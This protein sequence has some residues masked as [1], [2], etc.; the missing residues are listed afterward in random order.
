[1]VQLYLEKFQRISSRFFIGI[2]SRAPPEIYCISFSAFSRNSSK[3]SWRCLYFL[4]NF[5]L[6]SF[7]NSCRNFL[8]DFS[9][10]YSEI[11]PKY[12][13]KLSTKFPFDNLNEI[14]YRDLS[15]FISDIFPGIPLEYCTG[16]LVKD[17]SRSSYKKKSQHTLSESHNNKGCSKHFPLEEKNQDFQRF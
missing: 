3:D 12:F 9:E 2:P 1:M 8:I 16:V 11:S 6:I 13:L 10:S 14:I 17:C 4:R 7:L 15:V 5:S